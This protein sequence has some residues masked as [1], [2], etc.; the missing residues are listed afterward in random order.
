MRTSADV[1]FRFVS[2]LLL[3][4][5]CSTAVAAPKDAEFVAAK[6]SFLRDMQ[7]PNPAIRIAAVRTFS[8]VSHASVAEWLLKRGLFD[9]DADVRAATRSGMQKLA[10]NP[11]LAAG[12]V[13]ELKK[14]LRRPIVNEIPVELLRS[15]AMVKDETFQADLLKVLDDY[16]NSP[17]GNLLL[18]MT[19]IDNNGVSGDADTVRSIQFLTR[20]KPFE[21]HFGYRRSVIQ[22]LIRI[23]CREAVDFIIDLLPSIDG[24]IQYEAIHYLTNLTKQPFRDDDRAWSNWWKENRT[25][26]EFPDPNVALPEV[27]INEKAPTYYGVPICAKRVVF[28]L[29]TSGS[30][31]GMPIQAA[32]QTL[33]VAIDSLSESVQFDVIMFDAVVSRWTPQLVPATNDA[34]RKVSYAVNER[35]LGNATSSSFAL[36]SAFDLEPEVIFFLSD[37]APTDGDPVEIVQRVTQLNRVRRVSIHAVAVQTRSAGVAGLTKFMQ[38]LAE[39]NYGTFQLVK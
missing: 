20:A 14:S 11:D 5:I 4:A 32:K 21:S 12:L 31:A 30:M 8:A 33:L 28:V 23:R 34:K 7:L 29:D 15:L 38:P 2:M 37:G 3:L 19:A 17:K 9:S 25:D 27:P 16:L 1:R 35:G 13:D 10:T 6:Q 24:L 18:P 26:F 39:Q 36:K 22:A